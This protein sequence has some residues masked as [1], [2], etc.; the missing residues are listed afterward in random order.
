MSTL[1]DGTALFRLPRGTRSTVIV[2]VVVVIVVV[3]IV[4][5]VVVLLL[6]V[7]LVVAVVVVVVVVPHNLLGE[8]IRN[9]DAWLWRA[10]AK[11]LG[12]GARKLRT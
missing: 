7:V 4:V 8:P 10:Q 2:V 3:V 6:L 1:I 12:C 11:D 9:V 5:V